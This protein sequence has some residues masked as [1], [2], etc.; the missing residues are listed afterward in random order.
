MLWAA[1]ETRGDIN[2]STWGQEETE[3]RVERGV[4]ADGASSPFTFILVT[5]TDGEI[6]ICVASGKKITVAHIPHLLDGYWIISG[7]I[8]NFKN[9]TKHLPISHLSNL[10]HACQETEIFAEEAAAELPPSATVWL[11]TQATVNLPSPP[12][13]F[14]LTQ[15]PKNHGV[16]AGRLDKSHLQHLLCRSLMGVCDFTPAPPKTDKSR[17]TFCYLPFWIPQ[18]VSQ[19]R[20]KG[21]AP[22]SSGSFIRTE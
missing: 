5:S 14:Q 8:N 20:Y 15:H 11:A 4:V 18:P 3:D 16:G 17:L 22:A 12:D 10:E 6:K 21:E 19:L 13:G 7:F 1:V 2:H 9:K